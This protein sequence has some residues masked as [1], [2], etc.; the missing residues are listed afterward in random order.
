MAHQ[1]VDLGHGQ[2]ALQLADSAISC[3]RGKV[4][5]AAAALFTVLTARG[6]AATGDTARTTSAISHAGTLLST[7]DVEDEPAWI[8][9]SGF[10]ETSLASQAGLALRDLG[11]FPGAERQFRTSIATRDGQA[12]R[13]IHAL[14]LANLADVQCLQGRLGEASANWSLALDHMAGVR[15]ART[16]AAA[17]N[18]RH[19]L[20]SLGPRLSGSTKQLDRRAATFLTVNTAPAA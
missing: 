12:Y 7:A 4:T 20:A 1:A 2:Q 19:R 11:D 13:R 3:S 5:P 9:A 18:I 8:R 15:S 16:Y 6:H 17:R 14:T 10:T